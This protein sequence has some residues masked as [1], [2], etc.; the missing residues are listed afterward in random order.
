MSAA[1]GTTLSHQTSHTGTSR[2]THDPRWVRWL[3]TGIALLFL[4]FFLVL[5]LAAVFAEALRRGVGAYFAS[6]I[7]PDALASIKLTLM[8]AAISV[9]SNLV[10]GI[11][12]A[13]AITKFN[14]PGKSLL[15]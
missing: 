5:P 4:A 13:W 2:A 3:L 8:A 14:F 11:A 1:V 10:F 7:D 12:A 15:I 6:F 9:P